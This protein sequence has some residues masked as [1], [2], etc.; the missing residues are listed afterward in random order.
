[1]DIPILF[2]DN[3]I[4]VC[5]KPAGVASQGGELDV[6]NMVDLL[7]DYLKTKYE[8]LGNVYL[9]LIHRLDLNVGGVMV[10]AKTSKAAR[11]LSDQVHS[12]DFG[13]KYLA[14]VKGTYKN[15]E[16]T[17]ED[18]LVKDEMT[19][20]AKSGN[21]DTGKHSLLRY[22]VLDT[23]LF[24]EEQYS[25]VDITLITGRFHQ[26]RFQF[27]HHGHPL[28]GDKKYG[29][30]GKDDF[31]LGLF[32]YQLEFEHPILREK[33]IFRSKPEDSRFTSFSD[34]SMIDWRTL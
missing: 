19:R 10:F 12:D 11:R 25:L 26:I 29:G 6:K 17:L 14:I 2:E 3:H 18:Y 16:G 34:L 24:D 21:P 20:S 9:G 32:A 30:Q 22:K 7:K 33:M 1:M 31:F 5:I 15:A 27:A 28:Y 4:I 13:K 8:K 23:K